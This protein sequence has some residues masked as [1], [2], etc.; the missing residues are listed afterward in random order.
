MI[1]SGRP[2]D[3][4]VD[5]THAEAA[6][7]YD[8]AWLGLGFRTLLPPDFRQEKFNSYAFLGLVDLSPTVSLRN[9]RSPEGNCGGGKPRLSF[10]H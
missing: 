4:E 8:S 2:E 3:G 6:Q 9:A 1:A 5:G 10:G 7:I